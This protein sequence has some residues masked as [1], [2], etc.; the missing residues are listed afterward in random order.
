MISFKSHGKNKTC[1]EIAVFIPITVHYVLMVY[2]TLGIGQDWG[3][4]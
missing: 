1:D 4:P 2:T 3:Q